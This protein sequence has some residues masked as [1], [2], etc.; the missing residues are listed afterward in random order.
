MGFAHF[1]RRAYRGLSLT[2][3]N[4]PLASLTPF[5]APAPRPLLPPP[6]GKILGSSL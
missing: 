2:A 1:M 6:L 3:T 5:P 4:Q